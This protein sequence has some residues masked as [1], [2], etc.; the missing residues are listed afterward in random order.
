MGFVQENILA[1]REV[2][3]ERKH[4]FIEVRENARGRFLKIVEEAH[5]R[6]NAVIIPSTGV[7]DFVA[8]LVDALKEASAH[9][10]A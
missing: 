6:R 5:G 1:A 9:P 10:S 7:E 3:V 2:Q 8:N 4:Y